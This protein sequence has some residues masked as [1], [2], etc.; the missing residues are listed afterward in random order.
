MSVA[1]R[2]GRGIKHSGHAWCFCGSVVG[3]M[4]VSEWVLNCDMGKHAG[5][6]SGFY[7]SLV[8]GH[9]FADSLYGKVFAATAVKTS[10]SG[11]HTAPI[12]RKAA[13]A[14]SS[15]INR[16]LLICD[17]A[18]DYNVSRVVVSPLTQQYY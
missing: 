10:G 16:L 8:L 4:F 14:S 6:Y 17:P 11:C 13:L 2:F 12:R 1:R 9:F 3:L 15:R 7:M 5:K 18:S